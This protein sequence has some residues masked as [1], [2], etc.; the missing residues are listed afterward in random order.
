[1]SK[2]FDKIKT[3]I[4]FMLSVT[5]YGDKTVYIM[6]NHCPLNLDIDQI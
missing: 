2:Y 5:K 6:A 1:M 3:N 4:L